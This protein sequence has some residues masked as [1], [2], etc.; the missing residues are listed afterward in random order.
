VLLASNDFSAVQGAEVKH[1]NGVFWATQYHLEYDL[2]H[3]A[4]LIRVRAPRLL[5]E[6]FFRT[7]EDLAAYAENLRALDRDPSRKDLRWQ[8]DIA[9]DVLCE[10][11]RALEF[12]NWIRNFVLPRATGD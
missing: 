11:V 3:I 9:D 12:H 5:R 6:G 8:L 7:P 1:A 2:P 10:K 4:G